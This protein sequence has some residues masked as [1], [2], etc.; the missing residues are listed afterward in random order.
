VHRER[1]YH[2]SETL[3]APVSLLP[4]HP[5]MREKTKL[6]TGIHHQDWHKI[7]LEERKRLAIV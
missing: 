3:K 1:H 6:K 7:I 4:L 2:R 5:Y